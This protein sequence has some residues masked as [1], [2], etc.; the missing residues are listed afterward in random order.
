MLKSSWF[1]QI[2][3]YGKTLNMFLCILV[4]WTYLNQISY[5]SYY[6]YL[7]LINKI[8]LKKTSFILS[9][10]HRLIIWNFKLNYFFF[11]VYRPN[12]YLGTKKFCIIFTIYSK[13]VRV[14][15]NS[16][17]FHYVYNICIKVGI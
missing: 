2:F 3:L 11:F 12:K 16:N 17:N 13:K 7:K 14:K 15:V 9:V 8:N 10:P 6:V 4:Q 5:T 1:K